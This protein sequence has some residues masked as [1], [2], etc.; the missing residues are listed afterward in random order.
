MRQ[1][2]RGRAPN[3]LTHGRGLLHP[4]RAFGGWGLAYPGRRAT[5]AYKK[6]SAGRAI[7]FSGGTELSYQPEDNINPRKGRLEIRFK[8]LWNGSDGKSHV[9]FQAKPL[10]G[11]LYLGKLADGRLVFNMIGT[12]NKQHCPSHKVRTMKAGNWHKVT[13]LRNCDLG[14]ITLYLDG[15][16]ASDYESEPWQMWKLDDRNPKCRIRIPANAEMLIDELKIWLVESIRS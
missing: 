14:R 12:G 7:R 1:L 2:G 10:S 3:Q 4:F 15:Q 6:I 5:P 13:V 9:S 11:M 8:P 16:K